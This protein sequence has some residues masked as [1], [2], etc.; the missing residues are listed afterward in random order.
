MNQ[1]CIRIVCTRCR[2]DHG[3]WSFPDVSIVQFGAV[4]EK[5]GSDF[6]VSKSKGGVTRDLLAGEKPP[7]I[8]ACV[9]DWRESRSKGGAQ[10]CAKCGERSERP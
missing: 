7:Q 6:S 1:I 5:C 3:S 10:W 8:A 9:H 4:C 2:Y